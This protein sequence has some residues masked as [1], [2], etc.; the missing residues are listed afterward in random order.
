MELVGRRKESCIISAILMVILYN[1]N[2][3]RV[4]VAKALGI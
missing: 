1:P 4:P 3:L 2:S